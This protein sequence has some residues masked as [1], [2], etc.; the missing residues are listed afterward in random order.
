MNRIIVPLL[1]LVLASCGSGGG[2]ADFV[3]RGQVVAGPESPDGVAG[4]TVRCPLAD[5]EAVTD[6]QGI[7][8]LTGSAPLDEDGGPPRL[9][10]WFEQEGRA[11]VSRTIQLVNGVEYTARVI[12]GKESTTQTIKV[13]VEAKDQPATVGNA[14][15][16]LFHDSLADA[17]GSLVTGEVSVTG[18]T[19]EPILTDIADTPFFPVVQPLGDGSDYVSPLVATWFAV[20]RPGES[21]TVGGSQGM[22]LSMT[23]LNPLDAPLG[24]D[25]NRVFRVD[26][27][28]GVLVEVEATQY[29]Q[30]NNVLHTTMEDSGTWVWARN[31]KKP[32]CVNVNVSIAGG[33]AVLGAH[34]RL[35]D[36]NGSVFDE[37]L[38]VPGGVYCL[39]GPLGRTATVQA[40]LAGDGSVREATQNVLTGGGGGC[41]QGCPK[42]VALEFPCESPID[43]P[44]GYDC[45]MG[46]CVPL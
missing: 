22:G 28:S 19:W 39:R 43:C 11:S 41:D 7:F 29:D 38:G 27:E 18:A 2:G 1:A 12:L 25:D 46:V 36:E 31:V 26:S 13:P 40:W 34:L 8:L 35:V 4:V 14:T 24:P 3:L 30:Q 6:A 15:Y 23:S 5:E 10:I 42:S 32:T 20:S 45:V 33:G 37:Q 16:T 17:Q 21:L 44:E 9:G